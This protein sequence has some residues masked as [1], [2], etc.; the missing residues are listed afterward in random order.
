[1]LQWRRFRRASGAAGRPPIEGRLA[2]HGV[3]RRLQVPSTTT[4]A[5]LRDVIQLAMGVAGLPPPR[6][7]DRWGPLRRRR[8]RGLGPATEGRA[9]G[10]TRHGWRRSGSASRTS[11][12]S[13]TAGTTTSRSR[14]LLP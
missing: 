2:R 9:A 5:R 8:R 3:W 13:G 7:R 4:L 11:T 10:G 12:T 6:V 1:M 14:P